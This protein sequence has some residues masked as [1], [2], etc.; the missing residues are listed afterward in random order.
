MAAVGASPSPERRA[1]PWVAFAVAAG[2]I[3]TAAVIVRLDLTE[4]V[5]GLDIVWATAWLAYAAVG[6]AVAA[7]RPGNPVGPLLLA[8]GCA[9]AAGTLLDTWASA[10]L[11]ATP[12]SGLGAFLSDVQGTLFVPGLVCVVPLAL[13]YFPDGSLL[14]RVWAVPAWGAVVAGAASVL[15]AL[16]PGT[17]ASAWPLLY[18]PCAV[19][20]VASL[21]VRWWR[22]EQE[23]RRQIAWLVLGVGASVAIGLLALAVTLLGGSIPD[24][25]GSILAAVVAVLPPTGIAVAMLR[26]GLYDVEVI[27]RR[28]VVFLIIAV[29]VSGVAAAALVLIGWLVGVQPSPGGLAATLVAGLVVVLAYHLVTGFVERRVF[30][31]RRPERVLAVLGQRLAD[32]P[33]AAVALDE[34]AAAVRDALRSP[35]VRVEASGVRTLAV[36][37]Q[38]RGWPVLQVPLVHQ[39]REVGRLG[40]M[41]RGPGEEFGAQDQ[42]LLEQLSPHVAAAVSSVR[43]LDDVQRS[44]EQLAHGLE[45]ERRRLRRDLHDGIGPSLAAISMRLALLGDLPPDERAGQLSEVESLVD[46]TTDE[47]RRVV[48]G[49]RPPAL[50]D[51]GLVPALTTQAH[52]LGLDLHLT[53]W[54]DLP[55][56]S[57]ALEAAI[58]RIVGEALANVARHAGTTNCHAQLVR[59]SQHGRAGIAV[60]VAD[61]GVGL[62]GARPGVGRIAMGE[63]AEEVGGSVVVRDALG[64]GTEVVAWLPL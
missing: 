48:R 33:D 39:A 2:A 4:A 51:L 42:R 63:R 49:L 17:V 35:F 53:G 44:R 9:V 25:V 27:L 3:V 38:D 55:E 37:G 24:A 16:V 14:G 20:S 40:V 6:A 18:L 32:A 61:A 45:E 10:L 52:S 8:A 56:L 64:G 26:H 54:Q 15:D 34:M 31:D 21:G 50:D 43:L 7:R 30:G 57:A 62:N 13:L 19:A 60:T 41:R 1:W 22:D 36:C 47:L 58:Y 11:A 46:S 29:A 5:S 12:S 28:S 23:Q 59:A